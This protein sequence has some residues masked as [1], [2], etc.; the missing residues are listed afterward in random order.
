MAQSQQ[1]T[2]QH[3]RDAAMLAADAEGVGAATLE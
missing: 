3:L 2:V 1:K